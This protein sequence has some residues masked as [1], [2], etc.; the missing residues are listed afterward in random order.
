MDLLFKVRYP[1]TVILNKKGSVFMK[2]DL[3]AHSSGISQCCRI[4]AETVLSFAQNIDLD[5]IV[6]T[7]HYTKYYVKNGDV[8]AFVHDYIAEYE[9]AKRLGDEMGIKVF[10]GVEVTWEKNP[11][12]HI[13]LYGVS[14]DFLL[15]HPTLYDYS[16]K[17]L[18]EAVKAA[19]GAMIQAH[20][21][22]NGTTVLDTNLLDG[23]EIN[24]HPLYHESCADKLI[25]IAQDQHL[26]VT[27]GGDFHADTYRPVCAT[28]LP[29]SIVN[30]AQIAD[31]LL[32]A[33][34]VELL[35][36]EP[37]T[38]QPYRYRYFR[39]GQF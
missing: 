27:C 18:Y 20:P 34:R 31:F 29:D 19:G 36:H 2:I 6:L 26:I 39:D 28:H 1:I 12:V 37:L 15:Q 3:H 35:I 7:N 5:G 13:L 38:A 33:P 9:Y 21:Y 23:L 8:M 10:F 30:E 4:P 14:P 16:Q 11:S 22:R 24:C 32:S 17:A 25:R